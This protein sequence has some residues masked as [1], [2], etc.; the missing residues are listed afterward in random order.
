M[1]REAA[2][3]GARKTGEAQA[4]AAVS[5]PQAL[6]S[7]DRAIAAIDKV[8]GHP[9][10]ATGTGASAKFDPRNYIGGTDAMDFNVAARQIEGK[11]FLEA[12][13]SL[14]GGGAISEKEGEA[15]TAA[16][17]RLNRAQSDKEYKEG[18]R[19]LRR[20]A[21]SGKMLA[22]SKAGKAAPQTDAPRSSRLKFNPAT[23]RIE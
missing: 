8:L 10:L 13:A 20:I 14:K 16:I 17:A 7:A 5:L 4:E 22:K 21:M 19:E 11:A 12:F 23:N 1:A 6:A 2:V 15:A 3:S 9:G 18:L